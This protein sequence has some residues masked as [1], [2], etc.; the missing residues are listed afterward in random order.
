MPWPS[1]RERGPGGFALAGKISA[2]VSD[3]ATDEVRQVWD[4]VA[5]GWDRERAF[6]NEIE[7]P[8]T[9]RMHEAMTAGAGDTVLE[10]CAGPGEVGLQY[11]ER[12][13]DVRVLITDFAPSMLAA[14]SDEAGRRGLANVECRLIDAQDIDLPEAS[15]AGVLCRF[16][17]MLVPDFARAF[18]EIRRVLRPGGALAYSTWAPIETNP[19]MMILGLAMVQSGHFTPPEDGRIFP[20]TSKE[21]NAAVARGAGFEQ[22][23]TEVIERPVTYPSLERYWELNAALAGPMAPILKAL[24]E[25]ERATVRCILDELSAPFKTGEGLTFPSRR[26]LTVA[27]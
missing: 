17:L 5:P 4:A 24:G 21:E 18:S 27:S 1:W 14:A 22:V 15:V 9:A 25:E 11:A 2:I 26:L 8:L 16:G 13:P 23:Q 19:W 6:I 7:R 3:Q 10:L 20:L 12:H